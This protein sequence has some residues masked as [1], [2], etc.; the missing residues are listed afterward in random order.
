MS[1]KRNFA[2]VFAWQGMNYLIPL[3]TLP[4]LARVLQPEQFGV[5]GFATSVVAYA[6]MFTDWGFGLSATQAIAAHRDDPAALRRIF[7]NTLAAKCLLGLV[8]AAALAGLVAAVPGLRPYGFLLACAWLQ[9]A[10][11]MI[12]ADWFLQ[13][14]E[15][16]G[17]F[18]IASSIGRVLPLPLI[19]LFVHAPGDVAAAALI[20]SASALVAGAISLRLAAATGVPGR[21]AASVG[22]VVDSIRGGFYLFLSSASVSLYSNLNTLIVFTVAGPVEGGLFVGADKLRRAAQGLITPISVVMYP[23]ISNVLS[24]DRSAGFEM[25]RTLLLAQGGFTLLLSVATWITAPLVVRIILGP[26]YLDAV[27]VLRALAPVLFL[28]GINNV[29]GIQML[30]PLGLKREFL[31][32]VTIP[33][34]LSLA[35]M[36]TLAYAYG[37]VGVAVALSVTELLVNVV[38]GWFLYRRSE[39]VRRMVLRSA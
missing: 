10:G 8:S 15:M 9:V 14:M 34:V 31:L 23:R 28:V 29:L 38:A 11:G 5:L 32:S 21:P 2:S 35:Y 16:M 39:A 12:T 22:G 19:F 17:R 37:A 4:Y 25:I 1:L 24:R 3:V 20:Q 13:G 26:S 27:E 36:P 6:A 18:A 30:L 7:W 33:G